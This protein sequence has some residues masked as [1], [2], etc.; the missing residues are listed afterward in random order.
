[1]HIETEKILTLIAEKAQLSE[2]VEG[3]RSIL[4]TMFRFPSL[5]NKK[6]SQKTG[7]AIPAL[8][9]VRGELVKARI[10]EK[11]NFLGETGRNWIRTH[12]NL[13]YE[14][15]PLPNN[16]NSPLT[17]IPEEFAAINKINEILSNRPEPDF[18]LDQSHATS[19]TV[20][21][22]ALYLLK[23]GDIEG[24]KMVFLGDDDATSLA[25][26]LLN[27]AEEITVIDIDSNVVK[28]LSDSATVLSLKNYNVLTHDLRE[29]SPISVLN[30]CDVVVMDPPYTN[31]G[32]R[33]FLK[34]A[35]Q[36]LKTSLN[37]DG[38]EHKIIGKKCLLCFGNKPPNEMKQIQLSILD[39][40]FIIKEMIPYFNLYKG[41]SILGQFSHLYY[42]ELVES[43]NM[44][45]KLS[46]NSLPIYTAELKEKKVIPYRPIGYHFVGEMRFSDQKLLLENDKI[47]K[48]FLN[49]LSFA[50]LITYDIFHH[51]YQ[52][53][54]FS[55]VAMLE[56]S[57]AAI[58]TWPEH[59][60]IS[61]DIFICDE[62]PKGLEVI[63]FLRNQFKPEKSEFLYMERGK[64][65]M[66][67]YESLDL[68]NDNKAD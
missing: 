31:E 41:A 22:R 40:G 43:Q 32:L 16:F 26:A 35:K 37:I 59:G 62:F 51:N 25:V 68:E 44:G 15:D 3:V 67:K 39:H 4:L 20:V 61:V 18:A 34:R 48:I 53:Y 58:H 29:S 6:V 19:S 49:A 60:Y 42:L 11:K 30:N 10:I 24:R 5:K 46:L 23:K 12:L 17:E 54:G 63:K 9:A 64:G 50:D 45:D 14:R 28:F 57:H 55:A 56:T 7:I 8:A 65:S 47:Q 1:M 33:L 27:V 21:N 36:M 38:R 2:G 52:P 66:I 13:I